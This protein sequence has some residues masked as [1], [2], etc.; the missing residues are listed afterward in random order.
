M[1]VGK[2]GRALVGEWCFVRSWSGRQHWHTPLTRVPEQASGSPVT[3][4]YDVSAGPSRP[5]DLRRI[6]GEDAGDSLDPPAK[7][8][9]SLIDRLLSYL[10]T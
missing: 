4:C 5:T 2:W 1:N 3:D 9:C 7:G 10:T 6:T 8:H